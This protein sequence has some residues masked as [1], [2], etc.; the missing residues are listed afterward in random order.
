MALTAT[1]TSVVQ[2]EL[3]SMLRNPEQEISTVNKQNISQNIKFSLS[4][5]I[6]STL[7]LYI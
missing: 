1:A 5:E 4:K 3:L 2:Y 7:T 6:K